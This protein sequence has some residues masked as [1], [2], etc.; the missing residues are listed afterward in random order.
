MDLRVL[1]ELM[2]HRDLRTTQMYIAVSMADCRAIYERTHPFCC[3]LRLPQADLSVEEVLS[4]IESV[5]DREERLMVKVAYATGMRA[6]EL[7]SFACEDI[8]PKESKI[9]VRAGKGDQ[10]RYVLIDRTTL[11]P[12]LRLARTRPPGQRVFSCSRDHLWTVVK[13]A[14]EDAGIHYEGLTVSPHGLR[15]ACGS[16]CHQAGMNPDMVAKLLGHATLRHTQGYVHVPW[17][18]VQQELRKLSLF[19]A[20]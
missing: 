12:L 14:A 8:E 9:F 6:S 20:H 1:S 17:P 3:Q 19:S 13:E 16:H 10:D 2:G 18:R 7:L 11:K 4:V 5:E 15:H